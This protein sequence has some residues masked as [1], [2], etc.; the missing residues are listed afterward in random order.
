MRGLDPGV[1]SGFVEAG[2]WDHV[3][4]GDPVAVVAHWSASAVATRSLAALLGELRGYGVRTAVVSTSEAQEPLRI[5][6]GLADVVVRRPNSGYDFGSWAHALSACPSLAHDRTVMFVNDSMAGPFDSLAR[7]LDHCFTSAAQVWGLVASGQFG[8]HLQSHFLAFK[9]GTLALAPVAR[10]WRGVRDLG[11]KQRVIHEYELGLTRMLFREAIPVDA[12]IPAGMVVRSDLNPM[13]AGWRG[14]LDLG[15]PLVKRELLRHP[16]LVDDG[17]QIP[18]V[19][20]ERYGVAV[21]DW[22]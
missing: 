21:D 11:S 20:A 7:P 14:I 19:L 22:I 6:D 15:V 13:I 10:F 9:P 1:G 18:T 5:D 3:M 8:L 17:D 16:E 4:T 2:S 12:Y